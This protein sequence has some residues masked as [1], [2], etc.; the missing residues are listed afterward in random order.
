MFIRKKAGAHCDSVVSAMTRM[1]QRSAYALFS[2]VACLGGFM[3]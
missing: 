2:S 3:T 1:V